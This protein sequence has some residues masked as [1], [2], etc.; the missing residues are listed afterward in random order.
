M[1]SRL[2][3]LPRAVG[4][5]LRLVIGVTFVYASLDKIANPEGFAQAIF[6]YRMLPAVLLHPFAL[7]LPWLELVAGLALILGVARRGSALL[8][9]LMTAMFIVAIMAALARG[10]DISCGCFDTDSGHSV[11]ADLLWRDALLLAGC[12]L[13]LFQRR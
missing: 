13:L 2:L 10:L 4:L 8:I 1:T 6:Y 5:L 9:A 3:R 12:F 7:Y 11:G